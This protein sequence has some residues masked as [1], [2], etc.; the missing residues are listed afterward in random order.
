VKQYHSDLELR[1]I[2]IDLAKGLIFS[3]WQIERDEDVPLI[4]QALTLMTEA[5]NLE[6]QTKDIG[7]IYEYRT[8]AYDIDE[9][10]GVPVF[11]SF[12]TLT[13]DES[14]KVAELFK[15]YQSIIDTDKEIEI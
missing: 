11:I 14:L 2:A 4:F 7:M 12:N 1:Q 15:Q 5:Q 6:L 9:E 13:R 8:A 10:N 3:D